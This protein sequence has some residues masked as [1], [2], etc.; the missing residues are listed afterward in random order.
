ML[1]LL[2]IQVVILLCYN[3]SIRHFYLSRLMRI[4]WFLEGIGIFRS[5]FSNFNQVLHMY[6]LELLMLQ[7]DI[8]FNWK[9]FTKMN[10]T[11]NFSPSMKSWLTFPK[12]LRTSDLHFSNKESDFEITDASAC[13]SM[14][15]FYYIF[16]VDF[17]TISHL[18][19]ITWFFMCF[20][21]LF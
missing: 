15:Q 3:S 17:Y 8:V 1:R 14:L 19:S 21:Y 12:F 4:L 5:I 18:W 13:H 2:R 20:I 10:R 7:R 6:E 11:L 9:C 16:T